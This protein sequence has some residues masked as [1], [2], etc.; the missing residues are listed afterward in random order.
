M[1]AGV[2][3]LPEFT[4]LLPPYGHPNPWLFLRRPEKCR[5]GYKA[6]W[7]RHSLAVYSAAQFATMGIFNIHI[8]L[9]QGHLLTEKNPHKY[10]V[11]NLHKVVYNIFKNYFCNCMHCCYYH[12]HM[13]VSYSL[14]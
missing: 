3:L 6:L 7:V 1:Y 13:Y 12:M 14:L 4:A 9:W 5:N 10:T 11:R 2:V 8:S